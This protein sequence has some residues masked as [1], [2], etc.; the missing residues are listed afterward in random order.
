MTKRSKSKKIQVRLT[1]SKL[2]KYDLYENSVQAPLADIESVNRIYRE[3]FKRLPLSLREDFCGTHWVC[4][5]WVKQ[6]EAHTAL[7]LDLD[8]EPLE[9]GNEVH[10]SSLSPSEQKRCVTKLQNVMTVTSPRD[11]IM[12][13][14]FSYCIFKTRDELRKYFESARKSLTPKKG[15]LFLDL[16]GGPGFIEEIE[17]KKNLRSPKYGK[18]S[19]IWHQKSY[20]PIQA[21]GQYAIHY[22]VGD[23]MFRDLFTY[24]WRVWTIPEIREVMQEAGFKKTLVYWDFAK[25]GAEEDDYRP[26][27]VG[28]N[29]HAYIAYIVALA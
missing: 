8:P 9:Y 10:V 1:R 29:D 5:E 14:N 4:A 20:D 7:G 3:Q 26:A 12:A 19:Y 6:S 24:D 28:E 21:H 11:V 13:C 17:E 25:D 16:A 22:K 18:F 15:M 23:Q 27:E 2:D